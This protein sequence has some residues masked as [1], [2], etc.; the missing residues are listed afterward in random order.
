MGDVLHHTHRLR[1]LGPSV[2]PRRLLELYGAPCSEANRHLLRYRTYVLRVH[3]K[4]L[5]VYHVYLGD[6]MCKGDEYVNGF[7]V[8]NELF[9]V[10][11]NQRHFRGYVNVHHT[12]RS[13]VCL[14]WPLFQCG[15]VPCESE[16]ALCVGV[17]VCDLKRL[18]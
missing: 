5:C 16:L 7:G 6:D 4:A 11:R 14:L 17:G 18:T 9:G 8:Y 15:V 1:G 10:G 3:H 13:K 2:E 12:V